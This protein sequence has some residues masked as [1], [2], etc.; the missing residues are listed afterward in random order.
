MAT[1]II[2]KEVLRSHRSSLYQFKTEE[3]A[4][5]LDI[6]SRTLRYWIESSLIHPRYPSNGK[7]Y[8]TKLS[9]YNLVEI[10]LLDVMYKRGLKPS[11]LIEAMTALRKSGY[12]DRITDPSN[13]GKMNFLCIKDG[14]ETEVAMFIPKSMDD[15]DTM[16]I[17]NLPKIERWVWEMIVK[18][19]GNA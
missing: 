10:R 1:K 19:G 13:V 18:N 15:C 9:V 2:D 16:M 14:A 4:K 12:L 5:V 8:P 11:K 6:P 7:G 17:V 3:I